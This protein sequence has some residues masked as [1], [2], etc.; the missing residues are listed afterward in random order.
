[1]YKLSLGA[2]VNFF[3][4]KSNAFITLEAP[5]F[6]ADTHKLW[7]DLMY[8]LEGQ[9]VKHVTVRL[10]DTGDLTLR[11]VSVIVSLGLKLR[12]EA[13]EFELEAS[14]KIIAMMRR[15]NFSSAFSRLNEVQ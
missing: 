7:S 1:M 11:V 14:P 3:R 12:G 13:V 6:G 5:D 8:T 2:N 9:Q 10:Y 4:K 15:L